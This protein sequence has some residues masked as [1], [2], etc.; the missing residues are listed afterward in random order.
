[1]EMIWRGSR[2]YETKSQIFTGVTYNVY[3]PPRGFCF[4][5]NCHDPP[6]QDDDRL[7]DNNVEERVQAFVDITCQQ[8]SS[9]KTNH[10]MLTMGEDFQYENAHRWFKNLDKLI[11]YVNKVNCLF[12][13]ELYVNSL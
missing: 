10:I 11:H 5:D 13:F 3:A 2:N 6:I 1:M 12:Y 9:Y 4:D 8:A 7:F